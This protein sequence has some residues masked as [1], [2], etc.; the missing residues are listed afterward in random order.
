MSKSHAERRGSQSGSQSGGGTSA[1]AQNEEQQDTGSVKLSMVWRYFSLGFS[2]WAVAFVLVCACVS[3]LSLVGH[4]VWLGL[5]SSGTVGWKASQQLLMYASLA[6][7][8]SVLALTLTMAVVSMVLRA[9]KE[10]HATLLSGVLRSA[11]SFF[12]RTP[13]GRILNRFSKDL[14]F[15]DVTMSECVGY[16][17]SFTLQTAMQFVTVG[18]LMPPMLVVLAVTGFLYHKT[19]SFFRPTS[20]DFMRVETIAH[21]PMYTHLSETV[22]GAAT[23]RAFGHEERFRK[24]NVVLL[25]KA[26]NAWYTIQLCNQVQLVAQ[27]RCSL[28]RHVLTVCVNVWCV[29]LQ[30]LSLR[31]HFISV[32]TMGTLCIMCIVFR[33]WVNVGLASLAIYYSTCAL[34][35]HLDCVHN[36]PVTRHPPPLTIHGPQH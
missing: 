2:P 20:R 34:A 27:P 4:E 15:I 22:N 1:L 13:S 29:M 10:L 9:N 17:V 35:P 18:I 7:L 5:W 26:T 23:I 21:S 16:S 24:R 32:F 25:D 36:K 11:Q 31:L 14:G 28:S 3:Q 30:W 8:H 12:D 6:L 19:Q 33:S